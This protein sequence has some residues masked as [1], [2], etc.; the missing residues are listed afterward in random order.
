MGGVEDRLVWGIHP[1]REMVGSSPSGVEVVYVV[2]GKHR[3]D[4]SDIVF[5]A[6]RARIDVRECDSAHLRAL[7]NDAKHQGVAARMGA[8]AYA[9][10]EAIV[11]ARPEL[12]VALDCVQDPRNLGAI[13]RTAEAVGAG[14]VLLPKDRSAGVT[15]AVVRGA[16]G[17]V[18]RV[19]VARVTNLA[20]AV[21]TL[22]AEGWWA[23]GLL[24]GGRR[25]LYEVSLP[26]RIL[27]VIGGEGKGIRPLVARLCDQ[28]ASLPM[29]HGVNS[30]NASVAAG[31][32][33]Y[34]IERRRRAARGG[35]R[36]QS[37]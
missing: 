8:F 29:A 33:L 13:L 31:V 14:G 12:V 24:P 20:R 25:E 2:G 16:A 26:N 10:L 19:P 37:C 18:Y 23:V 9:E 30:L 6:H 21:G 17:H 22:K 36:G 3:P 28:H 35:L 32:A 27:L 11:R 7:T 15:A 1:V 5:R 4:I 34:E